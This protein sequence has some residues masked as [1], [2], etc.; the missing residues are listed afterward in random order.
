MLLLEEAGEGDCVDA[1]NG[2]WQLCANKILENNGTVLMW[3]FF[4]LL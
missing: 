3:S 4:A 1:F 2:Q